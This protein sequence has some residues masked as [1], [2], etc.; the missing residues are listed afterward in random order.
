MTNIALGDKL[1][2]YSSGEDRLIGNTAPI[3]PHNLIKVLPEKIFP[4]SPLI[5]CDFPDDANM[6]ID[7]DIG[8]FRRR[9]MRAISRVASVRLSRGNTNRTSKSRG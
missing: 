2:A 6:F 1:F 9:Q 8:N 7:P 5:G 4:T 3:M